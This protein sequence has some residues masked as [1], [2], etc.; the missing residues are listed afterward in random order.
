[1]TI[2]F[3][4]IIVVVL[5][6]R[7]VSLIDEIAGQTAGEHSKGLVEA[8][9]VAHIVSPAEAVVATAAEAPRFDGH[10]VT[11]AR[12]GKEAGEVQTP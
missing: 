6:V 3:V 12:G 2:F 8:R 7:E 11:C 10:A 1:M 5:L 4:S 9:L